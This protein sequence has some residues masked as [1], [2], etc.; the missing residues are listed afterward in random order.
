MPAATT[1]AELLAVC[2][3][4]YNKLRT[5]IDWVEGA[6]ARRPFEDGITIKDIVVHRVHWIDLF[7]K[8]WK[9]GQAGLPVHMPAEG[10]SWG[11]LK[12]YNAD[13]RAR[14]KS[15]S[16]RDAQMQLAER[17]KAL[18]DLLNSLDDK[19]LYGGPMKGGNGKWT[20]GR[21]AEASGS[22]HYRSAN[23]FIRKCLREA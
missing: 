20:T 19:A 23:K 1:K 18:M 2:E 15:V 6:L 9:D 8:W 11:D 14:T 13:L 3:K 4:E 12:A 21:Y 17:H 5:T 10:Y 22:S 7:L 16:W